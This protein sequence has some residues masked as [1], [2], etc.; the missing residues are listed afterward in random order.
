MFLPQAPAPR[1]FGT[2]GSNDSVVGG[3]ARRAVAAQFGDFLSTAWSYLRSYYLPATLPARLKPTTTELDPQLAFTNTGN[4]IYDAFVHQSLVTFFD[5]FKMHRWGAG[6]H[7][8]RQWQLVIRFGATALCITTVLTL[9]G[10][11]VGDFRARQAIFLFGC[12]G[13]SLLLAPVL[14]GTY[15]GRYT[16]P[17]AG[18]LMAAA[19]IAL[20]EIWRRQPR[21]AA[22]I[23]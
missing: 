6:V 16:L 22:A 12:G 3:W 18:P 23:G 9:I 10:L 7:A 2:F 5:R 20:R 19:G 4:A 14:T 15:A 13:L 17:M 11:G 21:A 8:L 1:R